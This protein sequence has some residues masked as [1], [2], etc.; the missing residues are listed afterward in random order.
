MRERRPWL[1]LCGVVLG[2]G[3][4]WFLA[5]GPAVAVAEHGLRERTQAEVL[6]WEEVTPP[7]PT[8]HEL[9]VG[10]ALLISG[11]VLVAGE[12]GRR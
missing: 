4:A 7:E 1:G 5:L 3:G 10:V 8:P 11:T 12:W 9:A 2:L 6:G